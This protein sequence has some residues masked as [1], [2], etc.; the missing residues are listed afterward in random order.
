[1]GS[2]L[3]DEADYRMGSWNP[4]IGEEGREAGMTILRRQTTSAPGGW[5][6]LFSAGWVR[7]PN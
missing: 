5:R 2:R 4:A 7:H 1:M 3:M 6:R